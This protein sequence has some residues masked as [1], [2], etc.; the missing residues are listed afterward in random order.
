MHWRMILS[1]CV[2]SQVRS[3]WDPHCSRKSV[4]MEKDLTVR[5]ASWPWKKKSNDRIAASPEFGFGGTTPTPPKLFDEQV[6]TSFAPYVI[7]HTSKPISK[8]LEFL[9]GFF[10]FFGLLEIQ[11]LRIFFLCIWYLCCSWCQS[12]CCRSKNRQCMY[13]YMYVTWRASQ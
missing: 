1:V 5:R 8:P 12:C 9:M 11:S 2:S 13:V 7:K 4:R 10:F 3:R 6:R